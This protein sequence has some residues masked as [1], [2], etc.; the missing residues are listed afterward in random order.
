MRF[1]HQ[2]ESL[3]VS[4]DALSSTI[5][6]LEQVHLCMEEAQERRP[7]KRYQSVQKIL[8]DIKEQL[9]YFCRSK[10]QGDPWGPSV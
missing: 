7:S 10:V 8:A 3:R 6:G 2:R 1:G 4:R 9:T 5:D